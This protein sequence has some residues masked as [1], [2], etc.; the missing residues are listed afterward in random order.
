VNRQRVL[1]IQ[2]FWISQVNLACSRR[3][4][5]KSRPLHQINGLVHNELQERKKKKEKEKVSARE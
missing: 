1:N 4:A 2:G 3:A 5:E